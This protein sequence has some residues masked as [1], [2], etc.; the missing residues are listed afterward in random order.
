MA[1]S[2]MCLSFEV[3]IVRLKNY[4]LI[5]FYIYIMESSKL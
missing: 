1:Y 2:V 3:S 4:I 5:F